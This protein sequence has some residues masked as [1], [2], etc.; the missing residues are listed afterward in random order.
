MASRDIIVMG[1]STGGHEALKEVFSHLPERLPASMF[2]V[3]HVASHS[4]NF[5][6]QIL[7]KHTSIEVKLAGD[8]QPFA[9]GTAYLA[10]SDHHLMIDAERMYLSRGPRENRVRPAVDPL[11]R[12]AALAHGC[13]AIGVILSGTLDDGTAGLKAVQT[14]GGAAIVQDPGDALAPEMPQ[15]A[16]AQVEAA[17]RVSARDIGPMLS[18]LVSEE[19]ADEDCE[20]AH[21]PSRAALEREIDI[22]RR[23]SGTLPQVETLGDPAGV[24]CPDCGGPLWQVEENPLRF[25]CH[26][27]HAFSAQ[28]LVAGLE[29]AEEEALWVALRVLEER[30]RMLRR[31]AGDDEREGRRLAHARFSERAQEAESH[32]ESIR[33]LL[34]R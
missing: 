28:N 8:G 5:L 9:P 26:T 6:P 18:R 13:R 7:Q 21:T 4:P 19:V 1:A 20:V 3:Q 16:L 2:V 29:D 34:T 24:S 15:N 25:R 10:P 30:V 23:Q 32:V 12:S 11:F 33:N 27:G 17:H 14:H 22:V 31:L